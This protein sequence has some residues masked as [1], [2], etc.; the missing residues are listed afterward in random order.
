M[1]LRF[2]FPRSRR[3]RS[4]GDF[5]RIFR[6]RCSVGNRHLVLYVEA[7]EVGHPRL[8]VSVSKRLGNAVA[9][10]RMKRRLREAFRLRQH[11]LPAV[12]MV[13]VIK[14]REL[15]VADCAAHLSKLAARASLRLTDT[16]CNPRR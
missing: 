1:T 4:G 13:C 15:S 10:N 3:I 12:D 16:A 7:N 8:G 5:R 9:R 14:T 11:E 2:R 6:R